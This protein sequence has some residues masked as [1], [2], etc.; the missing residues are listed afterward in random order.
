[1]KPKV[2]VRR[3]VLPGFWCSVALLVAGAGP[4]QAVPVTLPYSGQLAEEGEL[5]SGSKN[6]RIQIIG[7]STGRTLYDSGALDVTVSNGSFSILLGG[8]GQPKLRS[9]VFITTGLK[10]RIFVGGAVMS[11]DIELP[12][13]PYAAGGDH[14]AG[15]NLVDDTHTQY[16][17]RS[18]AMTLTGSLGLGEPSSLAPEGQ[19]QGEDKKSRSSGSRTHSS[20]RG[21]GEGHGTRRPPLQG[22]GTL[23]VQPRVSTPVRAGPVSVGAPGCP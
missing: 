13:S 3:V 6:M 20:R 18:G 21:K 14:S 5:V 9:S 12:L 19:S 16:V 4:L 22:V 1:M 17:S 7:G 8:K 2:R 11:P 23:V 10:L 15:D